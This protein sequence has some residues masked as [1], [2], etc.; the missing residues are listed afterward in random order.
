MRQ[1]QSSY[2][3]VLEWGGHTKGWGGQPKEWGSDVTFQRTELNSGSQVFPIPLHW[4]R[5]KMLL[6]QLSWGMDNCAGGGVGYGE[7]PTTVQRMAC[8]PEPDP[9]PR[10]GSEN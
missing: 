6:A 7:D 8:L 5:V 3:G 9:G 4:G 1:P 10:T 2:T